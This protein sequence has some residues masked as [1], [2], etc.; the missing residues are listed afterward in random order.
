MHAPHFAHGSAE[1]ARPGDL[2]GQ[3][4]ND[5]ASL[6]G[7][8]STITFSEVYT[9]Y[10]RFVWRVLRAFGV[11]PTIVEDVAQDVFVVVHRRLPEFEG[12]SDV[13]TWLFRIAKW[14]VTDERR[15]RRAKPAH[16]PLDDAAVAD[17]RPGPFEM[18]ARSEA[19]R[20]LERILGRMDEEKR[21]VFVLMDLEEMKALEV[22]DL[23]ATNVNTV[24]SRL[25][26]AREQFRRLYDASLDSQERKEP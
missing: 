2:T 4:S 21:I 11:P 13:R 25:R 10:Y 7:T 1:L 14:V 23:L 3:T 8:R 20:T 24:Y 12:R 6:S 16:E 26:L 5:A 22:A 17:A 18:A 19:V 15:R 9:Q